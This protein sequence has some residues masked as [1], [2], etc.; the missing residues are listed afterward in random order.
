MVLSGSGCRGRL[1]LLILYIYHI[2]IESLLTWKLEVYTVHAI[3]VSFASP[4]GHIYKSC[5][6]DKLLYTVQCAVGK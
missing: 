3:V 6:F 2:S 1:V 5:A 4:L